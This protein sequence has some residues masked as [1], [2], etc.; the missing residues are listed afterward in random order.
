LI[1]ILRNGKLKNLKL[2]IEEASITSFEDIKLLKMVFL[3]AKPENLRL[4]IKEANIVK[5]NDIYALIGV[6]QNMNYEILN[7]IIDKE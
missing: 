2:I 5:T 1:V 3:L 6:L 7:F 4:I